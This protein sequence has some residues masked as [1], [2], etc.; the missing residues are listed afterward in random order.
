MPVS[1]FTVAAALAILAASAP[2]FAQD[3]RTRALKARAERLTIELIA[4]HDR[5]G[6]GSAGDRSQLA[7]ALLSKATE[8]E[9]VLASL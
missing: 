2:V 4:D 9:A 3:A 5:Y 1:K 8:R 7:V 6:A